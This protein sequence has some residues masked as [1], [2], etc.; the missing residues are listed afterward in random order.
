M[1]SSRTPFWPLGILIAATLALAVGGSADAL[2][3]GSPEPVSGG[4][5][6]APPTVVKSK[7]SA[8][9]TAPPTAGTHGTWL[10]S[11]TISEYWPVPESWFTGAPVTA[12]GLPGKHRID[13]LYSAEG[14]SMNG[15]G[16][17]L[18]GQRYHIADLGSG[19]WVTAAGKAT[20]AAKGW[21]GGPPFWRAGGYWRSSSGAVTFPLGTG[22]WSAG[23]GRTYVPLV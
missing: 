16:I 10:S 19:G 12:P 8:A 22:G 18:D 1:G 3:S 21:L 14:V 2:A 20:N 13:W 6:I 17:G 11:V 5:A 15:E 23:S 7:V 4:A 9:T